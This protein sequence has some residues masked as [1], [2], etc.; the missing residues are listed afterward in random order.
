M[1]IKGIIALSIFA[2]FLAFTACEEDDKTTD[3]GT[4]SL[5]LTD[6]PIDNES[7]DSVN[8]TITDLQYHKQNNSWE[9]FDAYETKKVNLL[10]LTDGM[11]EML[12]S[13]EMEAG[14]YNQLR[15]MLDAPTYDGEEPLSNPGSYI[16]FD[17]GTKEELFVPSGSQTGY[18][19]VGAFR[20]PS[21]GE[22]QLTAD[23]DVRKSVV[24]AK[25]SEKYILKPTIRL[26]VDNE[27]G[28]IV[29]N[30]TNITD[31]ASD[32]N[33]YAYEDG[34]YDASAE[35]EVA[36]TVEEYEENLFPN[37]VTSDM[38]GEENGYQLNWLAPMTY[39]LVVAKYSNGEFVET[40][41]KVS[42]VEVT[43]DETTNQ[44]ID[45]SSL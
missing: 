35:T 43:S 20:V 12:G 6:A 22:V 10:D 41:G 15:F 11:T 17:D 25:N 45:L 24:N 27:A 14:Q 40:L 31:T 37:A 38:A 3:K 23:F 16:T 42:G 19:A 1:K 29:G 26:V 28:K 39:D 5:A 9:S 32:Y 18:K 13:F 4:L 30:V 44:E 8:I 7:V 36:D 21:N 34:T 33:V 2:L